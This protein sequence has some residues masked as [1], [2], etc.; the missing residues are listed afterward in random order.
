MV[1]IPNEKANAIVIIVFD[2]DQ[3]NQQL[4]IDAAINNTEKVMS[5]KPGFIS[6]SFHK[7]LDGKKMANY[8]QWEN[9]EIYKQ[10]FTNLTEQEKELGRRI[11]Q[12]ANNI[13]FNIY[14]GNSIIS[15][16]KEGNNTTTTT[17]SK[18]QDISTVV[19]VFS[20]EPQNQQKHIDLWKAFAEEIA[21]KQSGFISANLHKSFDGK[22]VAN[23]AQWER[24]EDVEAMFK[25][26]DPKGYTEQIQQISTQNWGAYRVVYTSSS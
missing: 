9:Q 24:K 2:V 4:L 17:L 10:A 26:P 18:E 19:N 11:S 21:Q 5:K 15:I 1:T 13:E 23:Y 3:N 16:G 8:A 14:E 22:R 12:F 20:V 7:S 6:A 25:V